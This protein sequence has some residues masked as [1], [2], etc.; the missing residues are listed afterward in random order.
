LELVHS[1]VCGPML[2]TSLSG[3][4][5][6][7]SFIDDYSRKTC[8]YFLKSKD[9]VLRK[10]KEFKALV[11]NLSERKIKILMSDNGGEYTSNEFGSFCR[12]VGIKRELTILYNPQ[13]N[14][15]AERK[16][17]TI[18]EAVKTIVI[19]QF[20]LAQIQRQVNTKLA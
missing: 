9:E 3:Y 8:V 20:V 13:Q 16:N 11:E 5:Y 4:V 10:F 7:V 1:D 12:D 18:M 14:G 6:Y 2:S 19:A 15:V 17:R